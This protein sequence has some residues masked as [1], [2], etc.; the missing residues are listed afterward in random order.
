MKDIL[1][2]GVVITVKF[3]SIIIIIITLRILVTTLSYEKVLYYIN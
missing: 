1:T 3:F 2:K